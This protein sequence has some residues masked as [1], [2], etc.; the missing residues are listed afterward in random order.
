MKISSKRDLQDDC[1]LPPATGT[2]RLRIQFDVPDEL[3]SAPP[4]ITILMNGA[5]IDRFKPTE[6]HLVR[7]YDVAPGP[8]ENTLEIHTDRTLS[9]SSGDRRDLGLLVR[10]IS[11][12]P[13]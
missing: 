7:E 10:A 12:G 2:T 1:L 6:A 3:M 4:T 8:G 13:P 5:T 9:Q 11:W